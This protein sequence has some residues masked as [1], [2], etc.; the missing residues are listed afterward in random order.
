MRS[1]QLPFGFHLNSVKFYRT[2]FN[3]DQEY[4][5]GD[6]CWR[7]AFPS[8][9]DVIMPNLTLKTFQ[10][11]GDPWEISV[12]EPGKWKRIKDAV[13]GHRKNEVVCSRPKLICLS[14]PGA[15]QSNR[16]LGCQGTPELIHFFCW[17]PKM[18]CHLCHTGSDSWS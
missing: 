9:A 3:Q 6:V 17:H 11:G 12:T 1:A 8:P 2:H 15:H 14:Q 5:L 18:H 7:K 10:T 4:F 13:R 16:V